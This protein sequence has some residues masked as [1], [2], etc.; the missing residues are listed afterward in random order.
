M[1]FKKKMVILLAAAMVVTTFAGCTAKEAKG[2]AEIASYTQGTLSEIEIN[3][4]LIKTAGLQSMLDMVDKNILDEIE[5]VT[6]EMNSTVKLSI[7]E[8]KTRYQDDFEKSL[9]VNGYDSEEDL[10]NAF[11]LEAQRMEYAVKHMT[12]TILTEEEVKEFYNDFEPEIQAS[13]ILVAEEELAIDL[14]TRI[15]AGEDFAEIAIEFSTDTGS[16]ALG[17]D[18]GLFGKGMM[19]PEFEAA[20]YA[21]AID[22]VTQVPVKSQFGYHI[23]KKTGGVEKTSYE[24]MKSDIEKILVNEIMLADPS[25]TLKALVQ[26]REDNGFEIKNT[27]LAEQYKLFT[28]QLIVE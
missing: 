19:V 17:G 23:I 24:E 7:D 26:L 10:K 21:L 11:L 4:R 28:E 12:S 22:E 25:I 5:P 16:G 6:E 1:L 15:G 9:K 18:L 8:I 13:H 20:A 2:N 14:I 27:V 3:E